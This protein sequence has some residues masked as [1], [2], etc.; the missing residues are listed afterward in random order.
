[1]EAND[2]CK[3]F[4]ICRALQVA[5]SVIRTKA[6][7]FFASFLTL[8][9]GVGAQP[10][11]EV[12]LDSSCLNYLNKVL[13]V[14]TS[15]GY[16]WSYPENDNRTISNLDMEPIPNFKFRLLE[17]TSFEGNKRRG[18]IGVIEDE[19]CRF[20]GYLIEF[21]TRY[22]GVFDFDLNFPECNISIYKDRNTKDN[23]PQK[24]VGGWGSIRS[25]QK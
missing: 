4:H 17:F 2:M 16:G 15:Y 11:E 10:M 22:T 6:I 21:S 7:L 18:G 23:F 8:V 20:N 14:K 1:M 5:I 24:S 19:N 12:S 9:V 13:I 25:D 3:G